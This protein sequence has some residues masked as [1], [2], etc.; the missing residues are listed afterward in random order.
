[1]S[2]SALIRDSS[3]PHKEKLI[4]KGYLKLSQLPNEKEDKRWEKMVD[5]EV[6]T[7]PEMNELI[8]ALFPKNDGK[9]LHQFTFI[10][11]H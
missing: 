6:L 10:F 4:S 2:E 8:N 5:K 9:K 11:S 3:L 7:D 1:M